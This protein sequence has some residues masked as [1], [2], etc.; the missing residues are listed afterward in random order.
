MRTGS[1]DR[2]ILYHAAAIERAAGHDVAARKLAA[3]S[4]AGSPRFALVAA[5]EAARLLAALAQPSRIA[6]R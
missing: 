3:A 6:P 4:L 2:E 1:R 5:P